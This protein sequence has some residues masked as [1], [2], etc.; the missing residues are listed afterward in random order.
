MNYWC[1]TLDET[2]QSLSPGTKN[3]QTNQ[4]QPQELPA[5]L[6]VFIAL[7]E[8]QGEIFEG[9]LKVALSQAILCVSD[10]KFDLCRQC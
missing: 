10:A 5:M 2:Q 8:N 7:P 9:T 4:P 3:K 6:M 1:S